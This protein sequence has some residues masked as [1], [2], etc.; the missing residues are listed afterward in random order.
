MAFFTAHHS[1]N[2]L[3]VETE[4]NQYSALH[5]C[6]FRNGFDFTFGNVFNLAT[7]II[8][9]SNNLVD[10]TNIELPI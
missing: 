3:S 7:V 6:I 5:G 2:K 10:L 1:E 9:L 4:T 8:I